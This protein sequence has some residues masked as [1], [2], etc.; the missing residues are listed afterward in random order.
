METRIGRCCD[1]LYN[2]V[3]VKE[4]N[5]YTHIHTQITHTLSLS[6]THTHT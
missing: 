5:A 3:C 4:C 2:G 1:S 6:L